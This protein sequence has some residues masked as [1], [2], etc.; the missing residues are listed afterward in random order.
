MEE[1]YH[2]VSEFE[3]RGKTFSRFKNNQKTS[4]NAAADCEYLYNHSL[5]MKARKL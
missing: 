3:H 5:A 1:S 4:L 2:K